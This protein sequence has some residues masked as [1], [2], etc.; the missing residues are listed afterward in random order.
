MDFGT[1]IV[2]AV[3]IHQ[4]PA[5]KKSD[6]DGAGPNLSDVPSTLDNPRKNYFRQKIVRSLST[7]PFKVVRDEES[8]SPVP[9]GVVQFFNS[10][11][12][13]LIPV[14]Q[15][16]ARHLFACQHGGMSNGLLAVVDALID[17]QP[18]LVVL[19]LEE[20]RGVQ[21]H[22]VQQGGNRT[23]E[24]ELLE[25][26]TLTEGTRVFK[27]GLFPKTIEL[28]TVTGTVSDNQ[29]GYTPTVEVA[30]FFLSRFLGCRLESTAEVQTRRF[31]DAAEDWVNSIEDDE[32]KAQYELALLAEMNSQSNT[33]DPKGFAENHLD[34][35]DRDDFTQQFAAEDGSVPHVQK[36]TALVNQRI[37]QMMVE[38]VNGLRLTG[39]P[40][41]SNS[42]K[43]AH[44]E[45]GTVTT[46]HS[47]IKKVVG[48]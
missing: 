13:D 28:A 46:I 39:T 24:V 48:K 29:R 44:D 45:D 47:A 8:T 35:E 6:Q 23:F 16:M 20:E 9:A 37:R 27:A 4:V 42:V 25:G 32:K 12:A 10:N 3:V 2:N 40:E 31:F 1:F 26:L 21:I 5:V 14:S 43:I 41:A 22:E 36:D 33:I 17:E 7:A 15:E 34:A 19:K 38:Y 30:D 18:C 11:G